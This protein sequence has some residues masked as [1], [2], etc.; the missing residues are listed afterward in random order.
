VVPWFGKIFCRDSATHAYIFASL[1]DYP[2]QR[3]VAE[4]M[5][6]LGCARMEVRNLVGGAMSINLGV[7][8]PGTGSRR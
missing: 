7:K 5:Q 1:K 3:G 2:A 4:K 6:A 8:A